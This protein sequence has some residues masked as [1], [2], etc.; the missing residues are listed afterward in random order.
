MR[1]VTVGQPNSQY[2][3]LKTKCCNRT[4]R[5][6]QTLLFA[7]TAGKK[8]ASWRE[9][10]FALHVRCIADQVATAPLGAPV[11]QSAIAAEMAALRAL[12]VA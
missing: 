4:T 11:D 9:R 5:T 12:A 8:N 2:H 6:G 1:I 3:G 7:Q 10:A